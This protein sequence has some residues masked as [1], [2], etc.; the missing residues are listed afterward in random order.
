[1]RVGESLCIHATVWRRTV[2]NHRRALYWANGFV[3]EGK[4]WYQGWESK[5]NVNCAY[6]SGV[7]FTFRASSA[8]LQ[9]NS[10]KN[11]VVIV[12]FGSITEAPPLTDTAARV[13]SGW[14]ISPYLHYLGRYYRVTL[15]RVIIVKSERNNYLFCRKRGVITIFFAEPVRFPLLPRYGFPYL[16]P[17][18]FWG[19]TPYN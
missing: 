9:R 17:L 2:S 11:F 8:L 6:C 16:L 1:M 5:W 18:Y 19:E 15:L 13:Y 12:I 10:T 14:V 7:W 3:G 4:T